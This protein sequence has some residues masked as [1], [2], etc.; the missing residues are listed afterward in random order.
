MSRSLE[1]DEAIDE[2]ARMLAATAAPDGALLEREY[3]SRTDRSFA[4]LLAGTR[5]HFVAKF[6]NSDNGFWGLTDAK[7][8]ELLESRGYLLLLNGTESGYFISPVAYARLLPKFSRTSKDHAV[9]INEGIVRRE[10]R[11]RDIGALWDLL[12]PRFERL[13]P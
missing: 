11:F 1:A 2:F 12:K 5:L 8:Q 7:A 3:T 9:R 13:P 4:I 10:Q 6:S